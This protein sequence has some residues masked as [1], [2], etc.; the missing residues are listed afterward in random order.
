MTS[1]SALAAPDGAAGSPAARLWVGLRRLG[2]EGREFVGVARR[3]PGWIALTVVY[4]L[5]WYTPFTDHGTSGDGP[6]SW[7]WADWRSVSYVL[8]FQLYIPL[9]AAIIVWSRRAVLAGQLR[10]NLSH[11]SET[12]VKR[13]GNIIP[14]ALGGALLIFAHLV[15]VKGFGVAALVIITWGIVFFLY[16]SRILRLLYAPLLLMVTMIPPPDHFTS[17]FVTEMIT[18]IMVKLAAGLLTIVG[19]HASSQGNFL[20]LQNYAVEIPSVTCAGSNIVALSALLLFTIQICRRITGTKLL[21]TLVLGGTFAVVLHVVRVAAIGVTFGPSGHIAALL[22]DSSI[23]TLIEVAAAA[24]LA[25]TAMRVEIHSGVRLPHG[26]LRAFRM[27][28]VGA[29]RIASPF[30]QGFSWIGGTLKRSERGLERW[31]KAL[32]P[33]RKRRRRRR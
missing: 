19:I 32:T 26:V 31:L 20:H 9:A 6:L 13:R 28:G 16:G 24:V 5:A 8:G 12:N 10:Y 27:A 17:L 11:Y 2:R 18:R 1:T 7:C 15:Q 4:L 21:L 33:K 14:L 25:L 29:D 22:S 23:V 30:D 3:N